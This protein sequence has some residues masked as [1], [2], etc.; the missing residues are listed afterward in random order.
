MRRQMRTQLVKEGDAQ[1][2]R[3]EVGSHLVHLDADDIDSLIEQLGAFRAAM[4]P[5]V[6]GK[7]S[8]THQYAIEVDP[9]WYAEPHPTSD[10]VVVFLRDTG[11]GWA[12]F[13]I[14]RRKAVKLCEEL[15][16]YA[17]APLSPVGL[18]N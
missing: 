11:I 1:V 10:A 16:S 17:N 18:A 6:P 12:G 4:L 8:R 15:S 3:L 7:V 5:A 2:V 9:S 14:S 13:A